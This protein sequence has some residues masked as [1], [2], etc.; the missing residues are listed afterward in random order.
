M[1]WAMLNLV[2]S[3]NDQQSTQF[4]EA[5]ARNCANLGESKSLLTPYIERVLMLCIRDA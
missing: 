5:L 1:A 2:P 3:I 4:A